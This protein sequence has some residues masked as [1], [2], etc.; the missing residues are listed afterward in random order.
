MAGRDISGDHDGGAPGPGRHPHAV[1]DWFGDLSQ[2]D[3]DIDFFEGLLARNADAV[4][5][6]RV[7]AEL[8]SQK[9]LVARAV[10]LDRHL[11][12]L[13]PDDFLARYNLACS[14]A[15]A[16]RPDEAIDALSRAILLGYDDLA[17][18]EVDPDLDSLREHPEFREL[19][20]Q[21]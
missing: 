19:L 3:F 4:E 5:V 10:E 13:L 20:G 9:G 1:G 18:L 8:V 14:L 11:V 17:H 12:D 21:E 7:L 15:R 2:L 6:L 16:G